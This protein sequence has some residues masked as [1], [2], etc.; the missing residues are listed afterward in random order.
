MFRFEDPT[1]FYLLIAVPLLIA[2]RLYT[3]WRQHRKAIHLGDAALVKQ[4]MPEASNIRPVVKFVLLLTAYSL[5]VVMLAR[6]QI[7]AKVSNEKRTGIETIIALDVSNSMRA[8]DVAPSRLDKSKMLVEDLVDNF[9]KDKI[10]LLVFAGEPFVQLPITSDYVSA[11]MFLSSIEPGMIATQGTDIAASIRMASQSFT[12]D[13]GVGK[14][15]IIITDGEDHEGGAEEAAKEALKAGMKV[16][17]LGV[18]SPSGSPIPDP[19]T[20]GYMIDRTGQTVMSALNEQMCRSIAAAGGGAYIHVDNTNDAQRKLNDALSTL[21]R[22]DIESVVYSEFDEQFQAFGVLVILLLIIEVCIMK[23]KNPLLSGFKLFARKPKAVSVAF[24]LLSAVSAQAQVTDRQCISV[25]NKHFRN[26]DFAKAEVYYR[27]AIEKN[28]NNSQAIYNLGNALL[29]QK[30]DSVAI[31]LFQKAAKVETSPL[32]KSKSFHNIGVICQTHQ[33]YGE[34]IEA[35]KQSLR[36]NP[37]DDETRYNLALC[38]KQQQKQD[39]NKDKSDQQDK[40]NDKEQQQNK[41]QNN[42]KDQNDKKDEQKP[43]K[44]QMSKE[45]AEQMLN[46]AIQ[47]EKATQQR[48]KKADNNQRRQLDKNW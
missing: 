27:K 1:Y 19:A 35:Y 18:G 13:K 24:V 48:L 37:N 3:S 28:A 42:K 20:K 39:Q 6:P 29:M 2:I 47:Q 12:Q 22:K 31:E 30:K 38:K 7:G 10:G 15:I 5:A 25:G 36:L 16:Y 41:D 44:E 33:M 23:K 32:R 46:A 11:K 34:A 21:A 17:V 8:E 40:G 14:A 9:N 45:N 4:L 43:P 26:G